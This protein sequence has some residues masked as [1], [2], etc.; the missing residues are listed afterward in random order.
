LPIHAI[1]ESEPEGASFEMPNDIIVFKKDKLDFV[2]TGS[3]EVDIAKSELF[4]SALKDN[5]FVFP[6]KL[7]AGNPTTMK[8]VDEGLLLI[9]DKNTL[10]QLKMIKALPSVKNTNITIQGNPLYLTLHESERKK[11]LGLVVTDKEVYINTY[12]NTLI[13]LPIE[14]YN[15]NNHLMILR[16]TPLYQTIV[17]SDLSSKELPIE[18]T[19]TDMN[20]NALHTN[21][22][23][24]PK[25]VIEQENTR[26][27]WL[28]FLTPY[29]IKQFRHDSNDILFD[30]KISPNILFVLLG[31]L[32]AEILYFAITKYKK[33]KFDF[34]VAVLLFFTGLPGLISSYIFGPSIKRG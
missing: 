26:D 20:F 31:I 32:L 9:D 19:A 21:N 33:E 28:S 11:Y 24:Y 10:F 7:F 13:K 8:N 17:K 4:T 25:Y 3:G 15:P 6:V 27:A 22:Q 23:T 34:L 18:Y 16:L 30:T 29:T 2:K 5:G 14:D 1:L 12:E